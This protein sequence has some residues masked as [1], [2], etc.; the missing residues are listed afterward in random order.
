MC[1]TYRAAFFDSTQK[2][3]YNANAMISEERKDEEIAVDATD[4]AEVLEDTELTDV[5]DR[6]EDKIKTLRTELKACQEE[7]RAH[8][9]ELQRAKADFLN[10]RRRLSEEQARDKDRVLV[11]FIEELLPL[12]DSFHMA[13]SD[14]KTWEA[15][16]ERWRKGVESI[17]NQLQ[18]ILATHNVKTL[19]PTGEAFDP[20]KH[21]AVGNVAVTDE[22]QHHIV[23]NVLQPGYEMVTADTSLVI[24]PARV[25]VGDFAE[26]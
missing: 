20:N 24:R 8:L 25:I 6:Q 19:N 26:A 21:D 4:E 7:K 10:A 14:T 3:I 15:V 18:S 11:R 22:S 9:E 12:C 5:E 13:M 23:Q 16:D 17:N 1:T 2:N